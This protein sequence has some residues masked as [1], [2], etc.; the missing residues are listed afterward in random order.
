MTKRLTYVVCL[1]GGML[2]L[3]FLRHSESGAIVWN[4]APYIVASLLALSLRRT[5]AVFCGVLAML[6]VDVWL[7][8]DSTL[9]LV[10]SILMAMSVLSTIKMITLFPFGFAVGFIYSKKCNP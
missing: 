1:V 7:V 9:Q 5:E 8:L 6:I 4:C 10:P 2:M 3:W